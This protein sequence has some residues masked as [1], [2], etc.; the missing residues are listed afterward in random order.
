MVFVIGEKLSGTLWKLWQ[1]AIIS[2]II[3]VDFVDPLLSP[4]FFLKILYRLQWILKTYVKD[5]FIL[6]S[7]LQ[8]SNFV[9]T[10]KMIS[11]PFLWLCFSIECDHL[12]WNICVCL[13]DILLLN[14]IVLSSIVFN[15]FTFHIDGGIIS[16]SYA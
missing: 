5:M 12:L 6:S 14:S 9:N 1:Y 13:F 11:P 10:S 15:Y 2:F 3:D 4:T 8:K 16:Q 7:W